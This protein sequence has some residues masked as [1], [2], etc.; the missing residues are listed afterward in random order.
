MQNGLVNESSSTSRSTVN[1]VVLFH[2]PDVF[3][4]GYAAK[5]IREFAYCVFYQAGTMG[6]TAA[7]DHGLD[8][9]VTIPDMPGKVIRESLDFDALIIVIC[10]KTKESGKSF[11]RI[12]VD[13]AESDK[14]IMHVDCSSK[15]FTIWQPGFSKDIIDAFVDM[16][17][18]PE[19]PIVLP[20]PI[21]YG[22]DTVTRHLHSCGKGE[23]VLCNNI[24]IGKANGGRVSI[25]TKNNRI[26]ST[27]GIDVKQHGLEKLDYVDIERAK[28]CSTVVLRKDITP[29]RITTSEGTGT[30]FINHAGADV[31]ELA[32]GYEGAVVVGDDT[33]RIVGDIL[34]RYS[35]PVIAITDGDWD[36][37]LTKERFF[38]DSVVLTV[39]MD[40][41]V[42][43]DVFV[44]I[45]KG[46]YHID[47]SFLKIKDIVMEHCNSR[48]LSVKQY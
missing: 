21:S 6:R 40:D 32:K 7:Y 1:N 44:E 23:F 16:G 14:P 30:A 4:K 24:L 38:T 47:T 5:F 9:V 10:P 29:P 48:L 3:D 41:E 43:Q 37:L 31:Y 34:F 18:T 46:K 20:N 25:T 28:C 42:G 17:F 26:V 22:H 27:T 45:F 12:I 13:H 33:S 15:I 19:A 2:G 35:K 39:D 11:S 36:R 8:M